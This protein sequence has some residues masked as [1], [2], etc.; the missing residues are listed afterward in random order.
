MVAH[1]HGHADNARRA[2]TGE[3]QQDP[4]TRSLIVEAAEAVDDVLRDIPSR[5]ARCALVLGY[6]CEFV[7]VIAQDFV[8]AV[9]SL[10]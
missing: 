7:D 3:L 1:G 4:A 10:R 6:T 5:G 9:L 8:L 2:V